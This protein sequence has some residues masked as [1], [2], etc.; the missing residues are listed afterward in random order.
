MIRGV[1]GPFIE[2]FKCIDQLS[3]AVEVT[4]GNQLFHVVVE[5]DEI[6][7]T[8]VNH[9]NRMKG[10][11]ATFMPLNRLQVR[12]LRFLKQGKGGKFI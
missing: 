8:L 2:L 7:T 4:A 3:A 10:G 1:Y 5:N 11:R 9:L 6:A 12:L